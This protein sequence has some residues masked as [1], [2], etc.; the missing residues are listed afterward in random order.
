MTGKWRNSRASGKSISEKAEQ[1]GISLPVNSNFKSVDIKW[2]YLNSLEYTQ[3]SEL[4]L[5]KDIEF[6]VY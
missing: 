5:K 1:M 3:L 2:I 4:N 6:K